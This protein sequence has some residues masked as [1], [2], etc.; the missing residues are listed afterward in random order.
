[1]FQKGGFHKR[2]DA[3]ADYFNIYKK[4]L[5]TIAGE[6]TTF[7]AEALDDRFTVWTCWQDAGGQ[8]KLP[9]YFAIV[10]TATG[11]DLA[12]LLVEHGYA[13]LYGAKPEENPV[14]DKERTLKMLR[15]AENRARK[16]KVGAWAFRKSKK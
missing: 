14:Q 10:I 2:T 3:Q 7:T 9:R 8:S 12:E 13:R 11:D 15:K 4:D 1:P 16:S 5:Y 6:A